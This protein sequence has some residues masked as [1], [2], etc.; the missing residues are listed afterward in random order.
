VVLLM[1][2]VLRERK[3]R[4]VIQYLIDMS[5]NIQDLDP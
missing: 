3:E 5:I 4:R 1:R 2:R